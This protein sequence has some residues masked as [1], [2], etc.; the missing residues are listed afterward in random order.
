M[1]HVMCIKGLPNSVRRELVVRT[2][3]AAGEGETS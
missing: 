1:W 3:Q 2:G